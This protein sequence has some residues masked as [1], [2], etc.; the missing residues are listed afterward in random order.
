MRNIV[1]G[2]CTNCDCSSSECDC[3]EPLRDLVTQRV[4]ADRR[5]NLLPDWKE[6]SDPTVQ[7][8]AGPPAAQEVDHGEQPDGWRG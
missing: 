4:I 5:G 8:V 7:G 6:R 1:N 3:A 2:W